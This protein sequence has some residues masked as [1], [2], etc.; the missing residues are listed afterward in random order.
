MTQHEENQPCL[1]R[2]F[3]ELVAMENHWRS[4]SEYIQLLVILTTHDDAQIVMEG[5]H[6][7]LHQIDDH[8]TAVGEHWETAWAAFPRA[9][10]AQC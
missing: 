9:K 10:L 3:D 7:L 4:V 6:R 8:A 5:V 1:R 2:V